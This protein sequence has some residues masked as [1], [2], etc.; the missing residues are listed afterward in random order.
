MRPA[1]K[2]EQKP[3]NHLLQLLNPKELQG[4]L[5]S[6]IFNIA[7]QTEYR[8]LLGVLKKSI[9]KKE[10]KIVLKTAR[11]HYVLHTKDIIHLEADGAYTSFFTATKKI[12]VSKN[13]KHYQNILGSSFIRCHQSFVVNSKYILGVDTNGLLQLPNNKTIPISVR[14]KPEIIKLIDNL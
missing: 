14:K 12:V 5:E 2:F 10:P 3:V 1:I 7:N 6:V 4:V 11:K 9:E 13:I 8:H